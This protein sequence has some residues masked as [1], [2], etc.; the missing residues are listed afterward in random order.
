MSQRIRKAVLLSSVAFAC[1]PVC[2]A[3]AALLIRAAA[4]RNVSCAN[5]VCI[6][7]AYNAV[8]NA[9]DLATMLSS[10]NVRVK[11]AAQAKDIVV[12]AAVTW[13]GNYRLILDSRR[14][15]TIARPITVAGQGA[16][17]LTTDDG[18]TGGELSFQNNGSIK[19]WDLSS[20]LRIDGWSYTLVNN[21]ATLA[22]DIAAHPFGHY[23][24]ANDHDAHIDGIY[25]SSPISAAF[26]GVFEG[27]GNSISNLSIEDSVISD[28][29]GM[30]ARLRTSGRI[31]DAKMFHGFVS[32]ARYS[33]AG[34]VVGSNDG[35]VFGAYIGGRVRLLHGTQTAKGPGSAG[36]IVGTNKGAVQNSFSKAMVAGGPWEYVGGLV[37]IN[38]GSIVNSH[39]IGNVTAALEGKAG[40]L[41]GLNSGGSIS[42]SRADGCVSSGSGGQA[43]GLVAWN[44]SNGKIDGSFAT[45]AVNG[46][47]YAG[48]LVAYNDPGT[49]TNSHASGSVSGTGDI[50]GLVG[51]NIG[52]IRTSYAS[53]NALG[54]AYV[55]ALVGHNGANSLVGNVSD[56]YG[57]GNASSSEYSQYIGGLIGWNSINSTIETSYSIGIPT[58]AGGSLVG[59]LVGRDDSA[60]G[61]GTIGSSFWDLDT[62]GIGDPSQG[63]GN[64]SN[65]RGITGLTDSQLKSGLPAGFD[66]STWAEDPNINGGNPYLIANPPN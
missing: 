27:L 63:A 58:G 49:I 45:G 47:D 54:G 37:G 1:V 16:L 39:A 30:F 44:V 42:E 61:S 33:T 28:S 7:T 6:A 36:A 46:A 35:V 12:Q 50:G 10:S 17:T 9:G 14:S 55:G 43:G 23:A 2:R 22:S 38:S 18:A 15:I 25:P 31:R 62:S 8:L 64:I 65:D 21:I 48:G 52:T 26:S 34:L 13:T 56:S 53:G 40:G 4:T 41:V 60:S 29:V 11:S 5:G 19:F 3:Q 57:T 20:S 24:L 59:G 66:P 32:A 51:I